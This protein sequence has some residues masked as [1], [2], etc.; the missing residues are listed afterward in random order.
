MNDINISLSLP[1]NLV[2]SLL[3]A[4]IQRPTLVVT[5]PNPTNSAVQSIEVR[6]PE[7]SLPSVNVDVPTLAPG[8]K[9]ELPVA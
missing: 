5:N 4:G 2:L 7:L 8:Q 9:V 6:L 1:G 3:H